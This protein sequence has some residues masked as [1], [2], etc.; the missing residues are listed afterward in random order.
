MTNAIIGQKRARWRKGRPGLIG[1]QIRKT[2]QCAKAGLGK[3]F[4]RDDVEHARQA[5]GLI[6][7][8]ATKAAMGDGGPQK[9][10]MGKPN[11]GPVRQ[12]APFA[13]E[14]PRVVWTNF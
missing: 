5:K 12:E 7:T 13:P 8:D 3:I 10:G 6:D 2:G 14:K 9:H 1:R 11:Y 4:C